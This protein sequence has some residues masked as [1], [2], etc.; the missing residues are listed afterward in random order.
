M[1]TDQIL[2][3]ISRGCRTS[4]VAHNRENENNQSIL[5]FHSNRPQRA[6]R[7]IKTHQSALAEVKIGKRFD[8]GTVWPSRHH[9]TQ[10]LDA[11]DGTL[12][13]RKRRLQSHVNVGN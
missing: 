5:E 2:L 1:Q 13:L 4:L 3:R 7:A 10:R 11:D 9:A 6:I 8:N 12:R